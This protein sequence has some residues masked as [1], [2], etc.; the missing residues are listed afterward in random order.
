MHPSI[1]VLLTHPIGVLLRRLYYI[2]KGSQDFLH[3]PFLLFL[4]CL[5]SRLFLHNFVLMDGS[6]S[7]K[8]STMENLCFPYIFDKILNCLDYML[9][10]NYKLKLIPCR[11]YLFL[12]FESPQDFIFPKKKMISLVASCK[13]V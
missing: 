2:L 7:I 4:P 10:L 6:S 8:K 11:L 5:L 12:F 1:Q 9:I 13:S 3:L